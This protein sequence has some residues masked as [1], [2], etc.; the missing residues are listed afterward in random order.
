MQDEP[1]MKKERETKDD[2]RYIIFF[3][4][5]DEEEEQAPTGDDEG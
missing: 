1:A 3:S 4:F 5:G 2:G